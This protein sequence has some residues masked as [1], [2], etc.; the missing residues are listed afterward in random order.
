MLRVA[1]AGAL[2]R[3]GRETC[4]VVAAASDLTLVGGFARTH[5]GQA[6]SDVL[7]L[8]QAAGRLYDRIGVLYDEVKPDVVVDFTVH[9]VTLDVVREALGR[10]ICAIVGATGWTDEEQCGLQALCEERGVGAALVPNFAL[11][12]V[13]AMRFA[14]QAARYFPT[15]EIVEMHHEGK[16]DKPSG[17]ARLTARR[18]AAGGGPDDVPIHSV[19]LRGVVAHQD[20][21]FGGEGELLTIRHDSFTRSSFMGGVLLAVRGV[22]CRKK[23]VIGLD[24]FLAEAS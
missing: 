23:L 11:G 16:R 24:D 21:L 8:P 4:A 15:A 17:T 10:G 19:R 22:R 6:L 9:P 18:I 3:M 7:A 14:E 13:L 5:A 1:V 12:A 2:G 20:V